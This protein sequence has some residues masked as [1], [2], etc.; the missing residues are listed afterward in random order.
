MSDTRQMRKLLRESLVQHSFHYFEELK[1]TNNEKDAR[2]IAV[3]EI[4]ALRALFSQEEGPV[5]L[6]MELEKQ[7]AFWLDK[8][9]KAIAEKDID[10]RFYAEEVL[11]A[12]NVL[13]QAAKGDFYGVK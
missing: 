3:E 7:E 6:L 8:D 9:K 10:T 13:R 11:S 5:S 12:I 1:K 4:D 2:R